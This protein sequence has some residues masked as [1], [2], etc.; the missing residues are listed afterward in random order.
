M[1]FRTVT[2]E[3][4]RRYRRS[5]EELLESTTDFALAG[6]FASAES[7]LA[8]APDRRDG[9]A[10]DGWD[11]V[12][13]DLELPGLGGIEA[14]RRL[15]E[16]GVG[17]S[18]VVLTVFEEPG[19]VL[20]AICAGADGY[21]VKRLPP[22]K[23]L[24]ELRSVVAGGSPLSPGVART[25]VRL[26]RRLGGD[27]TAAPGSDDPSRLGLTDRQ[28]DV[29]RCLADGLSYKRTAGELGISHNTVRSH[30]RSIYDELQVRNVAQAVS[31]AIR[32]GL[33]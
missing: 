14:T 15:K 4:D 24:E 32:E 20:R 13:M 9:S 5:L 25:A 19:T 16:A 26:L 8:D 12:L 23:I 3:D 10:L 7:A 28:R 30:I 22:E 21:L 29:L 18:V 11:L 27:G 31:R 6:S 2:V 17:A 1:T 33:V